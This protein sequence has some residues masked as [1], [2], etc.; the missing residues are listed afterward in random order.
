M[1][2]A[3]ERHWLVNFEFPTSGGFAD[4]SRYLYQRGQHGS[5]LPIFQ[6]ALRTARMGGE[7]LVPLLADVLMCLAALGVHTNTSAE[8]LQH[9]REHLKLRKQMLAQSQS[10]APLQVQIDYATGVA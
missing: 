9:S 3:L 10:D 6:I 4:L 7:R 2:T 1:D 5:A 8:V